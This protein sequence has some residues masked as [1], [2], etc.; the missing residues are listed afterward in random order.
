MEERPFTYV[1]EELSDDLPR[2]P[3]AAVRALQSM[4]YLVSPQGWRDLAVEIRQAIAYEGAKDVVGGPRLE[5]AVKRISLHHVKMMP[6]PR[7]PDANVVP[8]DLLA[9]LGPIRS[10]TNH[11]WRGLRAL[12]RRVLAVLARNT[13]LLGRAIDEILPAGPP[14][15]KRST[16]LVARS[17]IRVHPD[18]MHRILSADFHGGRAFV[19]ARVAGRR[20][21]R[22]VAEI[23][24]MQAESTVGTIELDWG[25]HESESVLFWQ[26]HA[27]NWDG[28]FFPSAALL[29][30][31]TASVALHDM[32]RELDPS[33]SLTSACI[34]DEAWESGRGELREAATVVLSNMG[35]VVDSVRGGKHDTTVVT[36]PPQMDSLIP[37]PP[38]SSPV[39]SR[40]IPSTPNYP[41]P[42][43]SGSRGPR[44]PEPRGPSKALFVVVSIIAVVA[45]LGLVLVAVGMARSAGKL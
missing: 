10:I 35:G 8:P 32:I 13:R 31:T 24:D 40:P 12:D 42:P 45:V 22:R 15:T 19:L 39:I 37:R 6:K 2:P 18:A 41:G 9:S 26:A 34:R 1:F 44:L 43:S 17:E 21:A 11:E 4:S 23:F 25:I 38:I 27:S 33:A 36:A 30:A 5:A 28:S 16:A 20:A 14:A 7:E 3:L 29:A